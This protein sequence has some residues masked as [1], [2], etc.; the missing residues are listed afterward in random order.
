MQTLRDVVG[1]F[2]DVARVLPKLHN[3]ELAHHSLVLMKNRWQW[4]M[5]GTVE[6]V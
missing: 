5:Y 6:S 2:V 1:V 4:N 3:D